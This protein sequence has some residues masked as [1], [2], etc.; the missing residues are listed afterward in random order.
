MYLSGPLLANHSGGDHFDDMV[1]SGIEVMRLANCLFCFEILGAFVYLSKPMLANHD[2]DDF[3]DLVM[4]I[5]EVMGLAN[6]LF[7]FS[8]K[9]SF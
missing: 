5:N 3:V 6:G 7:F 9:T 1:M 4:M 2:G 8:G